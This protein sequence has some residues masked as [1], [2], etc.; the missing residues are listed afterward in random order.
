[1]GPDSRAEGANSCMRPRR[2]VAIT[3]SIRMKRSQ[4]LGSFLLLEGRDDRLF[5]EAYISSEE[6]KIIVVNGNTNVLNVIEILDEDSF[7]GVLGIVDADFDRIE[8]AFAYS[9]NVVTYETHDLETML[10]SSPALDRLLHEFGNREKLED[11]G[12]DVLEA[13]VARAVLVAYLRLYSLR[14][15][16]SLRFL[17]LNYSKWIDRGQFTFYMRDLITEV[18]NRSQRHDLSSDELEIE[19]HSVADEN[20]PSY[21]MCNGTD[22]IE[23]LAIGLMRIL[24]SNP[25]G[26]VN[27]EVLRR[28]LRLAYSDE[29]FRSS[30][31]FEDIKGWEACDGNYK[32]IESA[33]R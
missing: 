14:N 27:A 9:K 21:E 29:M 22:L 4:Y 7:T 33:L 24:G 32:I 25:P 30:H 19:M 17:G 6:C 11:F 1:M 31:L 3:N 10:V 12:S 13:L 23:I 8:N 2:A 16:L 15:G 18:K 26:S 5:M 28:S 20:L